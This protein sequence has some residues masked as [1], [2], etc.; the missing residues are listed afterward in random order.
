M[1][2]TIAA[3]GRRHGISKVG[4]LKRVQDHDIPRDEKGQ[5]DFAEADRIWNASV[6]V[7][8]QSR[9]GGEAQTAK[10]TSISKLGQVQLQT[11]LLKLK[12]EKFE[13]ERLEGSFIPFAQIR[14]FEAGNITAARAALL[15][16]GAELADDLAG[17]SDPVAIRERI[18]RRVHAALAKLTEWTPSAA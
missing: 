12:R 7:Q 13:G 15:P 11:A 8:Q 14:A 9:R 5:I 3:W 16:I 17:I 6:N 4:A 2:G 1:K 18:D 10:V